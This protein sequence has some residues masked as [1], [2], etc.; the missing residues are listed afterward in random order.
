MVHIVFPD[1][2]WSVN[3]GICLALAK[4]QRI[5]LVGKPCVY[6]GEVCVWGGL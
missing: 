5:R 2:L 4:V 6:F 1:M 3:D